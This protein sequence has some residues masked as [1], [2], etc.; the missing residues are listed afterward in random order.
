[1][2]ERADKEQRE[3]LSLLL[4]ERSVLL[5]SKQQMPPKDYKEWKAANKRALDRIRRRI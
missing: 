4:E 1:M 3:E 2:E 5:A